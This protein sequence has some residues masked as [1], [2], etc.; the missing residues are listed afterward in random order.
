MTRDLSLLNCF[1]ADKTNL[2]ECEIIPKET[3][4][5]G[6]RQGDPFNW[7]EFPNPAA[8]FRA[9]AGAGAGIP[10]PGAERAPAPRDLHVGPPLN[11]NT[12]V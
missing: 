7:P 11:G 2:L 3:V 5:D 10:K 1:R 6:H 8:G 12:L 4:P 9:G